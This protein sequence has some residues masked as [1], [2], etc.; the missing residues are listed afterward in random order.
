MSRDER[1]RHLAHSSRR[2]LAA[3]APFLEPDPGAHGF[4][5]EALRVG[6]KERTA[7]RGFPA[8]F[9]AQRTEPLGSALAL[10]FL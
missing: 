9:T 4:P 7:E 3:R 8:P 6:G 2:H 10:S 5:Y 1:S